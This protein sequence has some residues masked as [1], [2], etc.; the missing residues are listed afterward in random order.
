M[1]FIPTR[2]DIESMQVGD[3]AMD[4]FGKSNEV[5]KV[6]HKGTDINGKLF[7][8]YATWFSHATS[9]SMSMKEDEL[10][11]HVGTSAKFTSHQLDL[12]EAE[13]LS[14]GERVRQL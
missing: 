7:V 4:C 13:M 14:R 5:V 12:I 1:L 6:E 2:N 11:R 9:I 3:K 10:V 8:C